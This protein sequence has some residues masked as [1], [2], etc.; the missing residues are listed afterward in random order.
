MELRLC[1]T[2]QEQLPP[3]GEILVMWQDEVESV[4]F[5]ILKKNGQFWIDQIIYVS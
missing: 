5:A 1:L 4:I 2:H 3:S